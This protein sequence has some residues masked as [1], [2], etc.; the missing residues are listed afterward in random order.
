MLSTIFVV[1]RADVRYINGMNVNEIN[2]C[3]AVGGADPSSLFPHVAD[4]LGAPFLFQ[5]DFGLSELPEEEGVITV[6]G[7]RQ[8]GKSTWL[9]QQVIQT[10]LY[11]GPGSVFYLNGDFLVGFEALEQAIRDL[12]PLFGVGVGVRRIFI[13]EITA[14]KDWQKALKRLADGGDLRG[15]QIV[16]TGSNA[17][18]LRRGVERLPGRKGKLDRTN[19]LFT[20]IS[21]VEFKRV[22]GDALG[23]DVLDAYLLTGGSPLACAHIAQGRIPEYVIELVKDWVYGVCADAGRARGS[24]L[25]VMEC[26]LRFG[27]TPVG[28]AKLAREAGLGNNT[29]AAGYVELLSDL[30]CLASS[31]VWDEGRNIKVRRKPC[32]YH[33]CNTLAALVWHPA[34]VRTVGGFRALPASVRGMWVEWAVSQEVWRRAAIRG[35]E[36]P[37]EQMHWRSK[38]HEID[39]VLDPASFLEVKL[40]ATNPLE[41]AWFAHVF[42]KKKLTVVSQSSYATQAIRGI[43]LED[44]FSGA[45]IS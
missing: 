40:G 4:L 16:T 23:E 41:F 1:N 45:D 28:Q 10:F 37:E 34:M 32:K 42:P 43:R 8:Y 39:F 12:L 5:W 31:Y 38:E 24:L 25:A 9:E 15:V 13:D 6:R 3:L 30:M 35:E 19:Y 26:L 18:D 7:A 2:S 33:F 44:F 27:G 20:P 14:V 22:C 21:F 11:Y 17:S 36:L 29:V